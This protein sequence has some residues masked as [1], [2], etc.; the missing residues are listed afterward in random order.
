MVARAREAAVGVLVVTVDWP[1]KPRFEAPSIA[2][3]PSALSNL[4]EGIRHPG[5]TWRYLRNG[6]RPR[7]ANWAPYAPA[8]S[9][10]AEILGYTATQWPCHQTWKDVARFRDLWPGKLVLK[11]IAHPADA[12]QARNIGVDGLVVSNHGGK[13]HARFP[14][15]IE[16]LPAIKSAVG[17]T[18]AIMIDGRIEHGADIAVSR[19]LGADFAF[20]GR[21]TLYGATAG[22][23]E[24]IK[25]VIDL[26]RQDIAAL[27]SQLG[28]ASYDQLN[29]GFLF[30]PTVD[31]RECFSTQHPRV[32]RESCA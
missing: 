18:M 26:L 32:W 24:G 11:G 19:C 3:P 23:R 20:F 17:D 29:E 22:G 8:G 9:G 25:R 1:I 30:D 13:A 12:Q 21:L 2:R 27:Q 16:I 6:G 14:A 4:I 5:W 28:C 10:P 15:T 31:S 7:L